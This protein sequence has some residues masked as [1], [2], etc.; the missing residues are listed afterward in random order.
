M[1]AAREFLYVGLERLGI[2]YYMS[3]A[4]FVLFQ[5]GDRAVEIRDELREPRRAGARPQLRNSRLR[6][7]DRRH[8]RQIEH[9][10][11]ELEA[12]W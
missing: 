12:I 11:N 4:N 9:F 3:Q 6:A 8:A 2:P 10:L 5:A 7:R 1:L